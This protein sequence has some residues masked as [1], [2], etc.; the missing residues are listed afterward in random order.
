MT[1]VST[2]IWV[3][4]VACSKRFE[5]RSPVWYGTFLKVNQMEFV[6][7]LKQLGEALI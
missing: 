2:I 5:Q 7:D 3:L 6:L 1:G 4:S